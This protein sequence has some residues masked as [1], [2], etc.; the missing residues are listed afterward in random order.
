M[1]DVTND[2]SF[3][4]GFRRLLKSELIDIREEIE[5]TI[6]DCEM[7]IDGYKVEGWAK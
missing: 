2:N 5:K 1:I 6:V 3:D 4:V 7:A